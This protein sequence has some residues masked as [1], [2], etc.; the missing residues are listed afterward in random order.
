VGLGLTIANML[1]TL[2]GGELT[3]TST[4]GVGAVFRVKLFL[5]TAHDSAA[6]VAASA[7]VLPS[8]TPPLTLPPWHWCEALRE[9]VSLGYYRGIMGKLDEIDLSQPQCA[10]FTAHMRGLARQFKFETMLQQLTAVQTPL[11]L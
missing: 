7:V 8:K 10:A 3:V 5:P 1:T 4:P 2:M 11:A 6:P 9:L